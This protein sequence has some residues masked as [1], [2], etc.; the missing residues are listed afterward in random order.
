VAGTTP[1]AGPGSEQ[2]VTSQ[3][4]LQNQERIFANAVGAG[5]GIDPRVILAQEQAEGA[6]APGG[7]GGFNFLNLRPFEPNQG[8]A[9][10]DVGVTGTS[11]G[12][13]DQ[14]ANLA[15][16]I[17]SSIHRF[18]QPFASGVITAAHTAGATPQ[19]E[20]TALQKSGWDAGGYTGLS[21]DFTDL[22]GEQALTGPA[23][24]ASVTAYP[25]GGGATTSTSS[26]GGTLTSAVPGLSQAESLFSGADSFFQWI[27]QPANLIR[28]GEVIAGSLLI[29]L[30]L[31][32]LGKGA[33]QSGPAQ[34]V[35]GAVG[36]SVTAVAS[37]TPPGRVAAKVGAQN[38][39][40]A[41]MTSR[42]AAPGSISQ[43]SKRAR[44]DAGFK[45]AGDVKPKRGQPG[46]SRLAK[47]DTIPF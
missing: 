24:N 8:G 40:A 23:A 47:G 32:L 38:R 37:R 6:Y 13:F 36:S 27:G 12:G 39:T 35:K 43:S 11:S 1:A 3:T 46:S 34:D 41:R 29:G 21:T 5:T 2:Q 45:P 7:T 26:L 33:T 44:R 15:D 42:Q 31:I 16:A 17:T 9:T 14:F 30:G 4:E 20:I 28:V 25:V 18:D 10:S 19:T 22:F